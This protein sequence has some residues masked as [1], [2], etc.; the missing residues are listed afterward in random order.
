MCYCG[1]GVFGEYYEPSSSSFLPSSFHPNKN[2]ESIRAEK[3]KD[4]KMQ[5]DEA[6][7]VPSPP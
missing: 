7:D 5:N 6:D 4:T 2:A 1:R 3:Y